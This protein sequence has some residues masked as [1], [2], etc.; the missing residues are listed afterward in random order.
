MEKQVLLLC[1]FSV[2]DY[3]KKSV[4]SPAHIKALS[5]FG[6]NL[7]D[8]VGLKALDSGTNFTLLKMP[9]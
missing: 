1:F 3:P 2:Q 8:C 5:L 4:S 7:E 6:V 9:H